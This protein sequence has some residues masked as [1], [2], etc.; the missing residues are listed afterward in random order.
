MVRSGV[1][2][3]VEG[4][5]EQDEQLRGPGEPA[6]GGGA[7]YVEGRVVQPGVVG[8]AAQDLR[9]P[10]EGGVDPAGVAGGQAGD[11]VAQTGLARA[12]ERREAAGLLRRHARGVGDG[13]GLDDRGPGD[14]VDPRGGLARDHRGDRG[15]DDADHVAR[16][17]T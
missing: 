13:V 2:V 15:V 8:V 16:Q 14:A 4:L 5:G 1:G 7:S 6:E 17:V 11:Q 3:L 10:G 12:P 9:D